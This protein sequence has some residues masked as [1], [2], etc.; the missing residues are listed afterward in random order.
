MPP[1]SLKLFDTL[2]G[3]KLPFRSSSDS[4]KL[5]GCGPTVYGYIHVGNARAF[6]V[7]DLVVRILRY[8]GY[9]V[10]YTRNYT[11][12]D[13]KIIQVALSEKKSAA[14][15]AEFY[16]RAFDD[17][18]KALKVIPPDH[19]PKATETIPEMISMIE[20]LI[21]KGL[22]YVVETS[23]G[24]DVYYR[25]LKFKKYGCLS[26]RHLDDM[27]SGVRIETEE[28][29][30]HPADFAL[31][32][33]AKPKE[34]SWESPWGPGR[35]GWHIECSAMIQKIFHSSLDIHMGGIDLIFP[36]HENEIAQS[37]GSDS[38]PLAHYWLH[39][40]ML[41][42]EKEKMSKSL[43][44]IMKTRDFLEKYG[45]ETLRLMVNLVHYRS[46]LDFSTESILRVEALVDRLYHCKL[47]AERAKEVTAAQSLPPELHHL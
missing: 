21:Q 23:I 29:K 40:G 45:A 17:D 38:K 37:E 4:L 33:A 13:D 47:H 2:Q 18:M 36:H 24:R 12:I 34:P 15:V 26:K 44:N 35:P 5:Y 6:L 42:I 30:E 28:K 27:I 10:T 9:A 25:V 7:Q 14:E 22:A 41:E 19:C 31:W 11:D 39:N 32:K 1:R 16:I 8:A 3:K 20:G 43:G 46:P